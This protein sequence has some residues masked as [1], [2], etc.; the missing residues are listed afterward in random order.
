MASRSLTSE[1]ALTSDSVQSVQ[2]PVD[3]VPDGALASLDEVEGRVLAGAVSR[4]SILTSADILS[5]DTS[6]GKGELLVPFRLAD[7]GLSTLVQAGDKVTVVTAGADGEV[8]VLARRA[9]VVT[10]RSA[11]ASG[12]FGSAAGDDGVLIVVSVDETTAGKLATWAA[13][14][15]LGIALG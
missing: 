10:V 9:R 1:Q 8:V 4:G 15:D 6:P 11:A 13:R 2:L 3:F 5:S 12:G 14:S 7:A